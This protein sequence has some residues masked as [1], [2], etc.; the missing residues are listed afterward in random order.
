MKE[1]NEELRAITERY[2]RNIGNVTVEDI[3]ARAGSA[4]PRVEIEAECDRQAAMIMEEARKAR[5]HLEELGKQH[6]LLQI[7]TH[8]IANEVLGN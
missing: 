7:L 3:V 6:H 4:F 5:E 1:E 8:R 2:I